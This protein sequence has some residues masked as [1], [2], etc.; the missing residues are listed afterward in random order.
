MVNGHE[1]GQTIWIID[2]NVRYLNG[3]LNGSKFNYW[4]HFYHFNTW[5]VSYSDPHCIWISRCVEFWVFKPWFKYQT[6]VQFSMANLNPAIQKLGTVVLFMCHCLCTNLPFTGPACCHSKC[7][8]IGH[9]FECLLFR[10]PLLTDYRITNNKFNLTKLLVTNF[11]IKLWSAREIRICYTTAISS[12]C[13][14]SSAAKK[15]FLWI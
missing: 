13:E 11:Q 8:L 9:N 5:H 2:K 4:R 10:S 14:T 12:F 15:L 6:L 1:I 7:K 3:G